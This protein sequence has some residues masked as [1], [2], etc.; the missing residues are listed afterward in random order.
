MSQFGLNKIICDINTP[1]EMIFQ[2][3]PLITA[4]QE[5]LERE[6]AG[7]KAKLTEADERTAK[8][9]MDFI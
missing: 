3:H 5:K 6:A 8:V 1:V 9:C 7:L 2:F 4:L